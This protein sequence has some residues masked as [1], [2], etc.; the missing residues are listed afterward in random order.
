MPTNPYSP[1][2]A[3][4]SDTSVPTNKRRYKIPIAKILA[5]LAASGLMAVIG[6]IGG[7]KYQQ[8]A[9]DDVRDLLG[10]NAISSL[11]RQAVLIHSCET[12]RLTCDAQ[13]QLQLWDSYATSLFDVW[14]Y[15]LTS[16]NVDAGDGMCTSLKL[17]RARDGLARDLQGLADNRLDCAFRA[18]KPKPEISIRAEEQSQVRPASTLDPSLS[19]AQQ[20][21]E[22]RRRI[23]SRRAKMRADAEAAKDRD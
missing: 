13:V 22:I 23:E 15:Y 17:I 5:L 19:K 10:T 9:S 20:V 1:P 7:T 21:E 11:R 16:H 12:G 4:S 3:D 8:S 6:F 14:A 2:A 18:P